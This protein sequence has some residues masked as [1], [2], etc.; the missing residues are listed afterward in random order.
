MKFKKTALGK[1]SEIKIAN[2]PK[3]ISNISSLFGFSKLHFRVC[4]YFRDVSITVKPNW[5]SRLNKKGL[6]ETKD[7]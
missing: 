6:D 4:E 7:L 1:I 5:G 2:S 3:K